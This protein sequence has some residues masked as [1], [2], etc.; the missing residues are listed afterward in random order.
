M[1]CVTALR[2]NTPHVEVCVF[3]EM[4]Q[5]RRISFDRFDEFIL[6]LWE[7]NPVIRL[8]GLQSSH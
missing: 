6:V 3:G 1:D 4:E 8:K 2:E 5:R 7:N